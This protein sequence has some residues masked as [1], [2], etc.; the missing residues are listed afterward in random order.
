MSE[1]DR[2]ASPPPLRGRSDREAIREGGHLHTPAPPNTP[3]PNPPPQGGRGHPKLTN[4][5]ADAAA[6]LRE[7][8]SAAARA[9]LRGERES[10]LGAVGIANQAPLMRARTVPERWSLLFVME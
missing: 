1:I 7:R 9:E 3:L 5:S 10:I 6:I 2:G 8:A 4:E